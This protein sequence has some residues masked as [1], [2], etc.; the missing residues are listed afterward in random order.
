MGILTSFDLQGTGDCDRSKNLNVFS[1]CTES[2]LHWCCPGGHWEAHSYL[3]SHIHLPLPTLLGLESARPH[4]KL[5]TSSLSG[6]SGCFL[7]THS[8][9]ITP[10]PWGSTWHF[11]QETARRGS[12][13]FIWFFYL[14]WK[15]LQI[16]LVN[17]LPVGRASGT[18]SHPRSPAEAAVCKS[19]HVHPA[20]GQVTPAEGCGRLEEQNSREFCRAC[21]FSLL[22][23][24]LFTFRSL[25][26][27]GARTLPRVSFIP[28]LQKFHYQGEKRMCCFD[29][30]FPS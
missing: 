22:R 8:P 19:L 9:L 23:G 21:V 4:C 16:H 5:A 14:S 27:K 24:M 15:R 10:T 12:S 25:E 17:A 28:L 18:I 20:G 29:F 3:P 13:C 6:H 11:Q 26:T 1:G 30:F 7:E 2:S